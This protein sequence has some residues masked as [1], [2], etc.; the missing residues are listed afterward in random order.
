MLESALVG[1]LAF[2]D[3]LVESVAVLN[4]FLG[5][6]TVLAV[7]CEWGDSKVG[8]E[9]A[10]A[11]A[12]CTLC[13][14]VGVLCKDILQPLDSDVETLDELDELIN[15]HVYLIRDLKVLA[16]LSEWSKP[17]LRC[18]GAGSTITDSASWIASEAL[19]HEPLLGSCKRVC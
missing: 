13:A 12:D 10:R 2:H 6:H 16:V 5:N 3:H 9:S 4:Y 8:G 15:V 19:V 17:Q 18:Q 7:A 14:T 1:N 11:I